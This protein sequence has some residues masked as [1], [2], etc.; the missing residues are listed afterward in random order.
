MI[1]SFPSLGKI[2]SWH[3]GSAAGRAGAAGQGQLGSAYAL[4]I[5]DIRVLLYVVTTKRS[6]PELAA[7][8]CNFVAV[9]IP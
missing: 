6:C 2:S 5:A 8:F 9:N 1:E 7:K 4:S 3:W